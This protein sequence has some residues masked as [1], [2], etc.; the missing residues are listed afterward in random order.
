MTL[1][2]NVV[3]FIFR[4]KIQ[5]PLQKCTKS[6]KSKTLFHHHD[7]NHDYDDHHH[8]FYCLQWIFT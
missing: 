2:I 5:N 8:H 1:L 4:T 3:F 7:Y 6:L